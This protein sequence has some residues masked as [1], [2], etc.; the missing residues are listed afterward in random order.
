VAEHA[1][2][3]MLIL[4]R[5]LRDAQEIALAADPGWRESRR[6]DEDT[7]AFNWSGREGVEALWGRTIGILGLGEIGAELARRL[8]GWGCA[9]LYHKRRRLPPHV[10]RDLGITYADP[11]TLLAQS[12]YLVNLLPYTPETD[13]WID[14][15]RL[16]AMKH[17][18][19]LVSCGSGSVID[20][21][22]LAEAIRAGH[23]GGA[24]LDTFEWEPL[25]ADNPLLPLARSRCNVLLTPHIAAGASSA[26]QGGRSGEY[27]NVA[28]H[29]AGQ[30]L[31][32]RL[33]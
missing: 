18:A 19:S 9:L 20:E 21:A 2:M 3:Q 13:G 12:D 7:F 23:L 17:G 14:A 25:R 27:A 33:V 31:Q 8:R 28:A 6:T 4:A 29:M 24:A 16:A 11:G 26:R 30:P 5:K 22:A 1:I 15:A 10:E 32:H